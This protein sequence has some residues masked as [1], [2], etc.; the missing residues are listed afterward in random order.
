MTNEI[1]II[2]LVGKA[3]S[4]KDTLLQETMKK[5]PDKFHEIISCTTRPPRENEVDG[6]NYYF[7][8]I[9]EFT[10]KLLAG[11]LLEATEF[12]EWHYGTLLSSLSKEKVNIGVFN[13]DGIICLQDNPFIDLTTIYITCSD[14]ERLLRQLNREIDPNVNEII[15]RYNADNEDFE[16]IEDEVY[17]FFTFKNENQFN[18]NDFIT[19]IGRLS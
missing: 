6:K 5:Y 3:G 1:K 18:L 11:D 9:E 14:K 15:R 4:G 10:K 2:A 17:E 19:F 13:I 12:N 16:T 7:L 8:S